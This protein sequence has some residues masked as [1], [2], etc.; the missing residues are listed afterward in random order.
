MP[1]TQCPNCQQEYPVGIEH[2]G[3]DM[4]CPQC[5]NVF[6]VPSF[7]SVLKIGG[8][9]EKKSDPAVDEE[10]LKKLRVLN[11]P[12]LDCLNDHEL[13]LLEQENDRQIV[14]YLQ[15]LKKRHCWEFA[16]AGALLNKRV[17]P[18]RREI[19]EVVYT[20]TMQTGWMKSRAK[21][22]TFIK[23]HGLAFMALLQELTVILSDDL[24]AALY[25]ESIV[26]IFNLAAK[27]DA[28]FRRQLE[29]HKAIFAEP[30]PEEEIYFRVQGIFIQWAPHCCDAILLLVQNLMNNSRKMR[31]SLAYEPQISVTPPTLYEFFQLTEELKVG[32]H[33]MP[34][35]VADMS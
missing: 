4:E 29:F 28:H 14:D 5:H 21:Y 35:V 7:L 16:V 8:A 9:E 25:G 15:Q 30:M 34:T 27:M 33:R 20:Q 2:I 17:R 3:M 32:F 6:K 11:S 23:S 13:T 10:E 24:K 12:V 1:N 31:D 22:H 26:N 19:V 18:L